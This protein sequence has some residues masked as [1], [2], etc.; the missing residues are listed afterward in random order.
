MA[1]LPAAPTIP[2]YMTAA[3]RAEA[4]KSGA[5][6][7]PTLESVSDAEYAK[8]FGLGDEDGDDVSNDATTPANNREA[9]YN[10]MR[11]QQKIFIVE[12][13]A[14]DVTAKSQQRS[15]TKKSGTSAMP[16]ASAALAEKH[17]QNATSSLGKG[18]ADRIRLLKRR[19]QRLELINKSLAIWPTKLPQ[20]NKGGN[21][22][23]A[24]A[25]ARKQKKEA[26][27][28]EYRMMKL[29]AEKKEG[30]VAVVMI[31]HLLGWFD[32]RIPQVKLA[33]WTP[34]TDIKKKY[35]SGISGE[36]AGDDAAGQPKYY[37]NVFTTWC[38]GL[39]ELYIDS[40]DM[41]PQFITKDCRRKVS[42]LGSLVSSFER[43]CNVSVKELD[44]KYPLVIEELKFL[45]K[46]VIEVAQTCN[47]IG[48][49]GRE[50]DVSQFQ[51]AYSITI[52]S[53]YWVLNSFHSFS[54]GEMVSMT[55]EFVGSLLSLGKKVDSE[56]ETALLLLKLANLVDGITFYFKDP[57]TAKEISDCINT[58]QA[59]TRT[60]IMGV[61]QN[62]DAGEKQGEYNSIIGT[63]LG[64]IKTIVTSRV[65][66]RKVAAIHTK[67]EGEIAEKAVKYF[68]STIKFYK[69][70]SS[71][72]IIKKLIDEL[73][74][75]PKEM[76]DFLRNYTT[77]RDT[78]VLEWSTFLKSGLTLAKDLE[79]F[80][81]SFL[82]P[83]FDPDG[84]FKACSEACEQ[85][86]QQFLIAIIALVFGNA[87]CPRYEIAISIRAI[88][89][90]LVSVMDL[91]YLN[92]N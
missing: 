75:I 89:F 81:A 21:G 12:P 80:R 72:P 83:E 74:S 86:T 69:P 43:S 44:K 23:A 52:G 40:H 30:E 48:G 15:D 16:T 92:S 82:S 34:H 68:I 87:N 71:Q 20:Q 14:D 17:R 46:R 32:P 79:K 38:T 13:S 47:A 10:R 70:F 26:A 54:A 63:T 4:E 85:C 78:T 77:V 61:F 91:C 53:T 9:L 35:S 24:A 42:A 31:K 88:C 37:R 62:G 39:V 27:A 3:E 73:E 7:P 90:T 5:P 56:M 6:P 1:D 51:R 58:I 18:Y 22:A 65:W 66:S 28:E 76:V 19:I 57:A 64:K 84:V 50:N 8:K 41:S 36:L 29:A 33:E 2:K 60:L 11:D 59:T 49:M 45:K 67:D 25:E 55:K